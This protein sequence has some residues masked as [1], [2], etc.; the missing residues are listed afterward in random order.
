MNR[1]LIAICALMLTFIFA[2][3]QFSQNGGEAKN[4][5]SFADGG[6]QSEKKIIYLTFDEGYENGC[7][8]AILDVL[9]EKRVPAAFFVTG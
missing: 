9:R 2:I 7:T 1:R 6:K 5:F 4:C 8:A 3:W